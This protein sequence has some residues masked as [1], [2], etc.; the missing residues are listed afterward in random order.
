MSTEQYDYI[1]VGA[2]SAGCVI[3]SR[4]ITRGV[5]RVLLIEAGGT[6]RSMFIHMP[7]GVS[8]AIPTKTWDY[9]SEPGAATLNRRMTVAQGK[10]LGGSS[11]VNGMIYI[12]GQRQDYDAWVDDYAC[13]GWGYDDLLPYFRRAEANESLTSPFHGNDGLLPVSENRYRHPLTMAFVRAG[14]EIGLPYVNDFNSADQH[15]VGYYQTTTARG[16]RASTAQTYLK[17]VRGNP[18]LKVV[19]DALVERIV[20]ESGR[21]IGVV[22]RRGGQSVTAHAQREVIVSAGAIGSPKLL[23]LSG[24]GPGEELLRH[25]IAVQ[26]ELPVGQNFVDHLH[27]SV[28][29][30]TREPIS[31]YG[32]DSGL[33]AVKNGV[34]WLAFRTGVVTSNILEGAAFVDTSGQGRPDVQVHFLPALDTWDD[35]DGI[36]RDRTHGLTLKVGHVQPKSRGSVTLA[37]KDPAALPIIQANYLNHPDDL[38]GQIRALRLGLKLLQAPALQSQIG[39][40]FSPPHAALESDAELERF[41]RAGVKTVYHPVGTCRMG[42]DSATSVVDLALRVHSVAGL[43]VADSSVFPNITSGNI[44][45]PVI[46]VAEKAVDHILGQA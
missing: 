46:A 6:D 13:A 26:R 3:A 34:Q 22:Y 15:G 23:L 10:V 30:E 33:R 4:L 28:N 11:S 21:A 32:E 7:A 27:L 31:L 40:V 45:A 41:V 24:I 25:G 16:A 29:A 9:A 37:S 12:R 19:T 38:A 44:N 18:A 39:E 43:R 35:P 2:G 1:V 14:Q 20:I 17:A 5:G 8:R 36:G 42:P